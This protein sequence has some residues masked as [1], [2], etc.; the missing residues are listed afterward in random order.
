MTQREAGGSGY[1]SPEQLIRQHRNSL[2]NVLVLHGTAAER[3]QIARVFHRESPVRGGPFIRVDCAREEESLRS[4]LRAWMTGMVREPG[5]NPLLG[6]GRGTLFLDAIDALS[7]SAQQDV[8]NFWTRC[9]E[10]DEG[11]SVHHWA[12]RL[13][14]GSGVDLSEAVAAG[15]F[16]RALEECV[17]K[18]RIDLGPPA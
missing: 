18:V 15:R 13:I 5:T 6:A 9:L 2:V 17:D 14:V 12:G 10:P 7:L 3:D 4:A 1:P 16:L 11:A 8:L